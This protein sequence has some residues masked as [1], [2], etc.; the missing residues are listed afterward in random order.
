[1]SDYQTPQEI[2]A[3]CNAEAMKNPKTVLT[4]NP[5]G[6]D[7]IIKAMIEYGE[8]QYKKGIEETTERLPAPDEKAIYFLAPDIMQ[9]ENESDDDYKNRFDTYIN[10]LRSKHKTDG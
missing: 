1:M 2:F 8:Q 7:A 4:Y 3:A 10:Y 6:Y 9:A 5:E